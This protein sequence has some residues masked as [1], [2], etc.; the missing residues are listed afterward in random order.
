[1]TQPPDPVNRPQHYT[2]HPSGIECIEIARHFNFNCGNAIKYIWHASLK[3]DDPIVDLK[4]A[5]FYLQDEINRLSG[6]RPPAGPS[7]FPR[8]VCE[9]E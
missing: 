7:V 3:D 4:K 5:I 6:N 8:K 9:H 2:S 1:M